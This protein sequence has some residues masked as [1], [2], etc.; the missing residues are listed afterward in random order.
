MS[1]VSNG[2]HHHIDS[3]NI[4]KY[5]QDFPEYRLNPDIQSS[6]NLFTPSLR[7]GGGGGGGGIL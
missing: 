7:A 1:I 5:L 2:N 6:P 3:T 4:S